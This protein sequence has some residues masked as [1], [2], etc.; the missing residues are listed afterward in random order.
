MPI[1]TSFAAENKEISKETTLVLI[2]ASKEL[3]GKD[4]KVKY[5]TDEGT[6]FIRI[7]NEMQHPL[8]PR[9]WLL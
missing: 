7:G 3:L 4:S 2:N 9:K 8:Q 1:A 5:T 6:Y